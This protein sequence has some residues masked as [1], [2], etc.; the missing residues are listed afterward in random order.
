M[1][2]HM[3]KCIKF[4]MLLAV[5]ASLACLAAP[6]TDNLHYMGYPAGLT[7][8]SYYVGL[9]KGDLAN[10]G[11]GPFPMWCVDPTHRISKNDWDVAI[12]PLTPS[13]IAGNSMGYTLLELQTMAVLG[14]GFDNMNP[15]DKMLQHAIWSIADG[16]S[17]TAGEQTL[18]TTAQALVSTFNFNGF[19][20]LDP[21]ECGGQMMMTRVAAPVPEPG[22]LALAGLGL[23]AVA[24]LSRRTRT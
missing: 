22:T 9:A 19:V 20:V 2:E 11:L 18:L 10:D 24:F 21:L 12:R 7:D 8:G 16:R 15:N 3:V 14:S 13:G 5:L 1:E 23:M 6:I 4:L 17:L